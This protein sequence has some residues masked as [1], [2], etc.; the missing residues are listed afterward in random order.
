MSICGLITTRDV[1]RNS[2]I[3]VREFGAA[4]YLR[5]CF[6]ILRRQRTTFLSLIFGR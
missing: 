1:L 3:I 4:I 5:C 2:T 6:A